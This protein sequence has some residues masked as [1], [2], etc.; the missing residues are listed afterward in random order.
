VKVFVDSRED[1]AVFSAVRRMAAH[2]ALLKTLKEEHIEIIQEGN[3]K[4]GDI[5]C[6]E[7]AIEHKS[8]ADYRQSI[9][10]KHLSDQTQMMKRNFAGCGIL[11]SGSSTEL[12]KNSFGQIDPFGTGTVASFIAQGIPVL[13]C[14]DLDTMAVIALKLLHK[15]NDTKARDNNPNINQRVGN[16]VQLRIVTAIPDIGEKHGNSLLDHFDT[17]ADIA[18]ASIDD[19]IKI[20]HIGEKRAIDIYSAFHS[21]R[22]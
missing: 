10:T 15:W 17:V 9:M 4:S 1:D 8:P 16:D 7:Y 5:V 18:N 12:F 3:M 20:P 14:D 19:L 11:Y 13:P 6:G 2:P 22:W 21:P